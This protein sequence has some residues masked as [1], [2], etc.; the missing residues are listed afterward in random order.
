MPIITITSDM[1]TPS[2]GEEGERGLIWST[3]LKGSRSRWVQAWGLLTWSEHKAEAEVAAEAGRPGLMEAG[4]AT[5]EG[6]AANAVS[7]VSVTDFFF[8]CYS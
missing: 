5:L 7:E 3:W 1:G 4:L 2:E 8:H 6:M